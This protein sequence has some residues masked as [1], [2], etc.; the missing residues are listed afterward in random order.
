[1]L[2]FDA[3]DFRSAP[4]VSDIESPL[5]NVKEIGELV[6]KQVEEDKKVFATSHIVYIIGE[7]FA[8]ENAL[9]VYQNLEEIIEYL[10]NNSTINK[11]YLFRQSTPKDYIAAV[12]QEK[13]KL[14][15]QK[16]EEFDQDMFPYADFDENT[17]N[18]S[19]WTGFY[20]SRPNFKKMIRDLSG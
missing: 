14:T 2:K 16:N 18:I 17:K 19:Y 15:V 4:I 8:W 11:K 5:Y 6:I 7:D 3:Y 12:H 13:H 9:F 1:M 10:N 20:S